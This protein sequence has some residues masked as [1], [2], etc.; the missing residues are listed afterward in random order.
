MCS[1]PS[2]RLCEIEKQRKTEECYL[3]YK[4]TAARRWDPL[5]CVICIESVSVRLRSKER[6]RNVNLVTNGPHKSGGI[7]RVAI[8]N[9]FFNKKMT[10]HFIRPE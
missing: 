5:H 7:N 6:L 8:L 10:E 4:N 1:L 9:G 2:Q 3:E